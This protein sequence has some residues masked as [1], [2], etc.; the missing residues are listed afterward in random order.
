MKK[1]AERKTPFGQR[2]SQ[3]LLAAELNQTE[4]AKALTA[5]L[6]KEVKPQTVQYMAG[7]AE[8]SAI[9]ADLAEVCGVRYEW[10]A[11]GKGRM[12]DPDDSEFEGVST[13]HFVE[14]KALELKAAAGK[15]YLP[16]FVSVKGGRAYT[17]AWFKQ[18]GV[19]PEDCFRLQVEGRSMEKTLFHGDWTLVNGAARTLRNGRV[20]VFQVDD[21]TRIKRFFK[22]SDGSWL[23]HSDNDSEFPDEVLSKED[24]ENFPV[25]GQVI[26]KSGNGGL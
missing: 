1:K 2:V 13:E 9:T 20:F 15:G 14:V 26:D 3:A 18:V 16:H 19:N 11:H 5:R 7:K 25:L 22:K 17:K 23:I 10:L 4:A 21:E 8:E 24:A 12:R 6:G